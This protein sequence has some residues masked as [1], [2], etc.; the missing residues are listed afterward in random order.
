MKA[1]KTKIEN[2]N[3]EKR[4]KKIEFKKHSLK[5]KPDDKI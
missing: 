1:K 2:V 3:K 5:M 4:K